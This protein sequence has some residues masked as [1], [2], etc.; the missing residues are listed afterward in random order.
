ML[1][2]N[3]VTLATASTFALYNYYF[4]KPFFL[5]FIFFVVAFSLL[6]DIDHPKSEIS[7]FFPFVGKIFKHRGFTH[8]ILGVIIIT[9]ALYFLSNQG[10]YW[11]FFAVGCGFIAVFMLDKIVKKRLKSLD[12]YS[13]GI[14]HRSSLEKMQLLITII[15]SMVLTAMLVFGNNINLR[16]EILTMSV[17]GYLLHIFGDFLTKEGVPLFWPQKH[18]IGLKLF[19]TGQTFERVFGV[20][21]LFV[22]IFLI[23]QFCIKFNVMDPIYWQKYNIEMTNIF[24]K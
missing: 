24:P 22:N 10:G 5:P 8:S 14:L 4:E 18:K 12:K 19:V 1:A 2:I 15:L 9:F 11:W 23:Y 6:P 7:K 16:N 21:L 17:L 13:L 20:V 3:H